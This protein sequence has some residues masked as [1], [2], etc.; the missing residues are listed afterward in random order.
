MKN[1]CKLLSILLVLLSLAACGDDKKTTNEVPGGGGTPTLQTITQFK[2]SDL[3]GVTLE[4]GDVPETKS[5]A[6]DDLNQALTALE[7]KGLFSGVGSLSAA[8]KMYAESI[9]AFS[10]VYDETFDYRLEDYFEDYESEG[11]SNFHGRIW[12]RIKEEENPFK[13]LLNYNYEISGVY[14]SDNDDY[15]AYYY[16]ADE[17]V[18][19]KFN[20]KGYVGLNADNQKYVIDM[21]VAYSYAVAYSNDRISA[22]FILNFG[23]AA[24]LTEDSYGNASFNSTPVYYGTLTVYD[25]TG[26]KVKDYTLSENDLGDFLF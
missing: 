5:E 19:A 18:H 6:I 23:M 20:S 10:V 7:D 21:N 12:G 24:S 26:N 17:Y 9:R 16:D 8:E 13:G 4:P 3:S 2:I 22:K 11:L 1:F 15:A 14:D 25:Y